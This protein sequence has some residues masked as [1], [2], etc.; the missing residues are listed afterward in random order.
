MTDF[1]QK[2]LKNCERPQPKQ[3]HEGR[4][5]LFLLHDIGR[6]IPEIKEIPIE[7][8][9]QNFFCKNITEN[10][11]FSFSFVRSLKV[12]CKIFLLTNTLKKSFKFFIMK[13][14]YIFL[15]TK[16]K[17][18]CFSY[19]RQTSFINF[20]SN[21]ILVRA[22]VSFIYFCSLIFSNTTYFTGTF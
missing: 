11:F 7:Y 14:F 1:D 6:H 9:F 2:F 15:G 12:R 16:I 17:T 3:I 13:K 21:T 22:L 10:L 20:F 5:V 18:F 8:L 4:V 19:L